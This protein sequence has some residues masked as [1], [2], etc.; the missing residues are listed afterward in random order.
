MI[1]NNEDK[2]MQSVYTMETENKI[3][4]REKAK[5]RMRNFRAQRNLEQ[6]SLDRMKSTIS[7]KKVGD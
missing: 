2:T 1:N 5:V 3:E 7:A 4:N 6:R